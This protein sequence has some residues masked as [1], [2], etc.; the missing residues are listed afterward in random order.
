[1]R[2][3][4]WVLGMAIAV[5]F[6]IAAVHWLAIVHPDH[7]RRAFGHSDG[8]GEVLNGVQAQAVYIQMMEAIVHSNMTALAEVCDENMTFVVEGW[9]KDDC[10]PRGKTAFIAHIHNFVTLFNL[11]VAWIERSTA[12]Y[13]TVFVDVGFSFVGGPQHKLVVAPQTMQI[14]RIVK[15]AKGVWKIGYF[16]EIGS[17]H[18]SKRDTLMVNTWLN[19]AQGIST[20]NMSLFAPYLA[21]NLTA[22]PFVAGATSA[23]EPLGRSTFLKMVEARWAEQAYGSV[24]T[25]HAFA[26]CRFGWST[27]TFPW[28]DKSG[29]PH[30]FRLMFMFEFEYGALSNNIPL[31]TKW[32]QAIEEIPGNPYPVPPR[33][34]NPV[35]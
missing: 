23:P 8:T 32:W 33:L 5:T 20:K 14:L 28:I 17:W 25:A 10:W 27:A 4:T 21:P 31:I 11:T 30:V 24:V 13:D 35:N 12:A 29:G 1:M 9:L 16:L 3:A 7:A 2:R 22:L 6:L 34:P 26:S 15:D 19:I 18:S